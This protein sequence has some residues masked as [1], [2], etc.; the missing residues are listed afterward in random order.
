VNSEHIKLIENKINEI[1]FLRADDG[2][3]ASYE[4]EEEFDKMMNKICEHTQS[5]IISNGSYRGLIEYL[6]YAIKVPFFTVSEYQNKSEKEI[7]D[8]HIKD[9]EIEKYY[10]PCLLFY[11]GYSVYA[12]GDAFQSFHDYLNRKDEMDAIIQM[13][14]QYLYDRA[15]SMLFLEDLRLANN[16]EQLRWKNWGMFKGNTVI[17]DYAL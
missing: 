9:S 3:I 2:E 14:K 5:K 17:F 7:W 10:I 1:I 8:K 13:S 4:E 6:G 11:K 16:E 12:Y 15:C